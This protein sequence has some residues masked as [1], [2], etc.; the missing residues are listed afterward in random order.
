M[1]P[2]PSDHIGDDT[3]LEELWAGEFGNAY[4]ERNA[5]VGAGRDAFWQTWVY[6]LAPRTALEV[7]CNVGANLVWLAR[8]L[9]AQN[10]AGADVN[11]QA[12]EIARGAAP[13]ADLRQANAGA[14]PFED[15]AFDLVFTT[16][17]L[18]H[19]PTAG[20]AAAMAEIVR[21]SSRYVLC[22]E[23]FAEEETEVLYRGERGALFK[24]DYGRLYR[25]SFPDL[26]LIEQGFLPREGGAWDDVT[27]WV[28][29]CARDDA[30]DPDHRA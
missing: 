23:Y 6:R 15:G 11:E 10:V 8:L 22:G 12:L 27:Y 24:R 3:R 4:I 26:D 2:D 20:L 7:G 14:L 17:V 13:G 19:I 29:E 1:A 5:S 18:I 16:G 28:F 25:E 9:G 30:R 21:C